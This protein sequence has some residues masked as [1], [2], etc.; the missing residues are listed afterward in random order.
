MFHCGRYLTNGL[1][2]SFH[3]RQARHPEVLQPEASLLTLVLLPPVHTVVGSLPMEFNQ[4]SNDVVIVASHLFVITSLSCRSAG[5]S[6]LNTARKSPTPDGWQCSGQGRRA[7]AAPLHWPCTGQ[8]TVTGR[9]I[10]ATLC[11][12]QLTRFLPPAWHPTANH[13]A[14]CTWQ[15]RHLHLA[16]ANLHPTLETVHQS[17]DARHL[18]PDTKH[19]VPKL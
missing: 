1:T 7:R 9:L 2:T 6:R 12:V 11:S 4:M 17:S 18:A 10:A 5:R 13:C 16:P 14:S 3:L 19:R 15:P 8:T